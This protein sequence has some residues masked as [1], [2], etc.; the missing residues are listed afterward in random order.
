MDT[1]DRTDKKTYETPVLVVYGTITDLTA[2]S[3][4][5]PTQGPMGPS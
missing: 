3:F 1:K 4:T 5:Y 2:S